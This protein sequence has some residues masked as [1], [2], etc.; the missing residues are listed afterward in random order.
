MFVQKS[1]LLNRE[2]FS[3]VIRK[4][5]EI[6]P[7]IKPEE[8]E[9]EKK[10]F[11]EDLLIEETFMR[12]VDNSNVE[13]VTLKLIKKFGDY[14][15]KLEYE[16]EEYNPLVE[17]TDFDEES[18]DY[19]R[20]LILKAN[21]SLMSY[22]RTNN[23][24]V[25]S[26]QVHTS[27]NKQAY[28]T[29]AGMILGTLLGFVLKSSAS[30]E[31]ITF[32][33]D[34]ISGTVTTMF[35]NALSMM[36]APLV[37]FSV[38]SGITGMANVS[39][40]GRIGGKLVGLYSMTTIISS[41]VG[42]ILAMVFFSGGVPPIVNVEGVEVGS[43]PEIS[44]LSTILGIIPKNLIDPIASNQLIQVIFIA[45]V[46]GI[47]IN[48]LGDKVKILNDF[49]SASNDF[50]I[51]L[52]TMISEFVPVIAFLSMAGLI[53]ETGAESLL[54][55]G[56]LAVGVLIGCCFMVFV[57]Y[58]GLL[59]VVGKISP[60][61]LLKKLTGFIMIPLGT[62]SSNITMPFTLKFCREKLGISPKLSSFSIPIGATVNMDGCGIYY[63]MVC[64]MFL[65]MYGVD[66]DYNEICALFLAVFTISVGTPG[67]PNVFVVCTAAILSAFNIP[68]N[69]TAILFGIAP[70]LDRMVTCNNVIGDVSVTTALARNEN[71]LDDKIY[72][73]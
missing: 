57:V 9:K 3:D 30:P 13:N 67:V 8:Q 20:M 37:F 72:L 7:P 54:V 2:N 51:T 23:L 18:A 19:F 70:I 58:S 26:I 15:V 47:T 32:F 27:S 73:N 45:V 66:I 53:L 11:H 5:H 65:K 61:P 22:T 31:I 48:K 55:I 1:Y 4:I 62:S 40:A 49:I 60:M 46:F 50:C 14:S 36:L 44:L 10:I 24:N 64:I 39:N 25:V 28:L 71:M 63:A 59:F 16:G 35:M 43:V 68:I 33:S 34:K 21:R 12:I 6:S 56:K 38:I 17:V 41:A 69:A 52:V 42:L 29:L